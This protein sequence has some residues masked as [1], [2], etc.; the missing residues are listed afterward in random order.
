[1]TVVS[2][3]GPIHYL[4]LLGVERLLP[5]L[6]R[7]VLVPPAV[8]RELP[9]ANA[10]EIVKR[11]AERP[12]EWLLVDAPKEVLA[13]FRLDPGETEAIS[14]AKELSGFL[15]CDDKRAIEVARQAGILSFGTLGVLQRGHALK[16]IEIDPLLEALTR[17]NYRHTA[18]L[19][20]RVSEE[21][22]RMRL[23]EG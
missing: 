22:H 10:P 1:M 18:A 11:W 14:L 9:A 21:A 5:D 17:T 6:F 19:F 20:A 23:S 2:D 4:L 3:T 16:K 13:L 15:L 7:E 8:L 12:P